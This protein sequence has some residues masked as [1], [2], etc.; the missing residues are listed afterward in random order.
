MLIKDLSK[1]SIEKQ[2]TYNSFRKELINRG[3]K[4]IQK[5]CRESLGFTIN[6]KGLEDNF[7][8]ELIILN[9][10]IYTQKDIVDN[11]FD[12]LPLKTAKIILESSF[13]FMDIY[14]LHESALDI[15]IEQVDM[16]DLVSALKGED[17]ELQ[18]IFLEN[19]DKK[20]AHKLK[21]ALYTDDSINLQDKEKARL[22]II[23]I[24]LW[25]EAE[26]NIYIFR[27]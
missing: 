2:N 25:L 23:R 11:L 17:E 22:R 12:I 9:E 14:D 24:I 5:L 16:Q 26:K 15:I 1:A 3:N 19:M 7:Q 10:L 20:T 4:Q 8:S 6:L 21:D 27:K 13:K 18:K